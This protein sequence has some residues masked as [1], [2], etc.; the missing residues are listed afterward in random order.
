MGDL[1]NFTD[2]LVK[3]ELKVLTDIMRD[4]DNVFNI[5]NP[6]IESGYFRCNITDE[7]QDFIVQRKLNT[8]LFEMTDINGSMV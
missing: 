3:R 7:G 2:V 4:I 1:I 6:R 8:L 5:K